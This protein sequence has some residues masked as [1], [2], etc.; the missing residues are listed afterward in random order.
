MSRSGTTGLGEEIWKKI[1]L[2]GKIRGA[3]HFAAQFEEIFFE[4]S[5]RVGK[6]GDVHVSQSIEEIVLATNSDN[7]RQKHE[8]C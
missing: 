2:T 1:L 4:R 3:L 6:R 5:P 7:L 8:N